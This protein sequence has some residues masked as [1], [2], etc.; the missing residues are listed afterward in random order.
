MIL[1][2]YPLPEMLRSRLEEV[3]LQLKILQLGMVRPFL[4][5]V[6]DPPDPRAVDHSI[7][8]IKILLLNHV[9]VLYS[10]YIVYYIEVL[11]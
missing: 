2:Q 9:F 3:V 11:L 6:M 7:K 4:E 8:V 1:Q 10:I 5:K